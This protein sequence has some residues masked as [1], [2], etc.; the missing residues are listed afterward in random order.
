MTIVAPASSPAVMCTPGNKKWYQRGIKPLVFEELEPIIFLRYVCSCE[1]NSDTGV[2][3]GVW[4]NV[5]G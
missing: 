5:R 1:N 2:P 3:F 4:V